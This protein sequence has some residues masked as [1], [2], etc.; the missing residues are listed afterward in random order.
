M[1]IN[2]VK[3]SALHGRGHLV[4]Q[5]RDYLFQVPDFYGKPLSSYNCKLKF[6]EDKELN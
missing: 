5:I 1:Q 4:G 3:A 2:W 6:F